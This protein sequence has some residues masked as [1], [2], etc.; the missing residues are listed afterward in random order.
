[1]IEEIRIRN[2]G[3]I[4]EAVLPLGPGFTAITGE[5]GAGK[6]MVV[7]A[8]GLLRGERA[9]AATV[10]SGTESA[11]VEGRWFITDSSRVQSI[12]DDVDASLDHNELLLSR[13]V[14]SEGRSRAVVAGRQTPAGILADLGDTLV[15]VHGQSEQVR[16]R[17]ASAQ[18]EALDRFGG[19]DLSS[20][21]QSYQHVYRQWKADTAELAELTAAR[22]ARAREAEELRVAVSEI[23]ALAPQPGED[24]ALATLA[25]RLTHTEDLRVALLTAR[26]ALA[27]ESDN[28]DVLGLIE[29]ARKSVDRAAGIDDALSSVAAEL[30]ELSARLVD[31]SHEL[32]SQV[33]SLEG[34]G[35]R[36]LDLVQE[37]RAELATVIRR[38]GPTLDDVIA[39][40]ASA[41]KRLL[42]LDSDDTRIDELTML[43]Q[44]HSTTVTEAAA[45]LTQLRSQ[46]ATALADAVTAELHAL[47]MP[48]AR[49]HVSVSALSEPAVHGA[50]VVEIL[51]APHPGSEP[52][53]VAKGASGGELSRIMLA[54]EV[55]IA[56]ADTVPT[57]VFDEVDAG[58]G[59]AA[60][61][62]VGRRL[63]MLSQN[64]QVIVVTH[65]AQVAAFATNHL[66]VFK[67]TSGEVTASSVTKLDGHARLSEMARLLSGLADSESGLTHA[68]EL[69]DLAAITK[70]V[71][72]NQN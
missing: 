54:L 72:P 19:A 38:Y 2:L 56:G 51:L 65:L 67:D 8:L 68:R 52:R 13:S 28:T 11:V 17:S 36:D 32:S 46:A 58:V 39:Y 43:V 16:L 27:S 53:P 1:V 47:A 4:S 24:Q 57:Y 69:L 5:T 35:E 23:E 33:A 49:L 64:A 41:S 61:I 71:A 63:A 62:E 42:E 18:R 66:R 14:T 3:V 34:E 50:D 60:A 29:V 48:D 9:E 70:S 21:L 40:V 10:R 22:D 15:A 25:E 26:E 45:R 31:A 20:A 59:G 37:R 44:S 6:T 30:S 12:L 55:V 7:T